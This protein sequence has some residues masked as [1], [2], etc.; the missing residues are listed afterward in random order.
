MY[1]GLFYDEVNNV[2][3]HHAEPEALPSESLKEDLL[4]YSDTEPSSP[5]PHTYSVT[6][7]TIPDIIYTATPPSSFHA[8]PSPSL[9]PT[10]STFAPHKQSTTQ[11]YPKSPTNLYATIITPHPE[12]HS[13]HFIFPLPSLRTIPPQFII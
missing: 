1:D 13:F 6:A 11:T 8:S 12:L 2:S 9:H 5:S 7:N 10:V 3:H 4:I